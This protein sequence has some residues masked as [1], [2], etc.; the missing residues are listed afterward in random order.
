MKAT[1]TYNGSEIEV[2]LT[3]AQVEEVK[4]KAES[5]WK[6]L[7]TVEKC[8]EYLGEDYT[9]FLEDR[10]HLPVDEIA[11]AE[12]KFIVK[13]LNGGKWVEKGYWP[14]FS[15]KGSPGG[16]SYRGFDF[17]FTH[18]RVG[19]RLLLADSERAIFAGKTFLHKYDN[20]IN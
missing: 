13:A 16:F 2:S 3:D 17:D 5:D 8:F 11:H 7:D 9:K 18:S 6:T 10:K 20:W 4:R 14:Y 15:H 12:L 1:T 19:S